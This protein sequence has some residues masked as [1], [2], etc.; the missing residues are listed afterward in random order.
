VSEVAAWLR[1]HWQV[2]VAPLLTLAVIGAAIVWSR[3]SGPSLSG[4]VLT[5][6]PAGYVEGAAYQPDIDP[7]DFTTTITNP[8]M[9]LSPGTT[10][11]YEGQGERIAITVTTRTRPVM[12]IDTVVVRERA[13]RGE[14]LVEDTEDWFA[15]DNEGNVWYF[16]EDTAECRG[17]EAVN[18][19]GA[20]E[21]GVDGAQPGIVMLGAPRVG[22]TYRQEYYPDHAED[23]ARVREVGTT[24][25]LEGTQYDDVLVTEDFTRLEPG[26]LEHKSY[27]PELGLIRERPANGG[28]GLHLVDVIVDDPLA[29]STDPLCTGPAPGP[30]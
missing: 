8:F 18:R 25:D 5:D 13:W 6:N 10:L 30:G 23:A 2:I 19:H 12:G 9:P 11:A 26:A 21:A 17:G 24:V 16:G 29:G 1:D 4:P 28:A 20:W 27:A 7:A 3:S 14:S 22:D 15:Q